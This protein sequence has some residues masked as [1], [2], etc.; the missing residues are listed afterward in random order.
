MLKRFGILLL[1]IVCL[2]SSLTSCGQLV[3]ILFS[4]IGGFQTVYRQGLDEHVYG[5]L[6][7]SL[8]GIIPSGMLTE[9]EY[10]D[11]DYHGYL[12]AGLEKYSPWPL[13]K[14]FIYLVYDATVYTEAKTYMLQNMLTSHSEEHTVEQIGEY[15]FYHFQYVDYT[16]YWWGYN[17]E[18]RTL[19]FFGLYNSDYP[20]DITS[21]GETYAARASTLY[22]KEGF[23]GILREYYSEY[24][25]FGI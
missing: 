2:L 6:D 15:V 1:V 13:G 25:D 20:T 22:E 23:A 8:S 10:E 19:Y 12:Q 16:G 3:R 4:P 5:D 21:T 17:D 9:F 18:L 24:Y 11:G 7:Y 14:T